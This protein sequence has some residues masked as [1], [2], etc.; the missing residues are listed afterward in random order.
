MKKYK[1]LNIGCKV[2]AY[3]LNAIASLLQ[4][5]GFVEDNENPDVIIVNTCS[6]TV[7]ADRKSRQLIR[8]M[9]KNYPEAVVAVMGCYAQEHHQFIKKEIKPAIVIGTSRRREIVGLI[10]KA[11]VD[12]KPQD[13][14]IDNNPRNFTYEE[15]GIISSSENVRAYLKIQDGC[16]NFCTYC[17]IPYRRGKMR[18]RETANVI[19]E[20]EHLIAQG[21]QEI[22]LTGIHIGGY[23]QDLKNESFSSLVEQLTAL[24]H[25][26]RLRISSIEGSEID[27]HLIRLLNEKPNLAKH[28]HTP[29]QSGS[30]HILKLM[31]RKYSREAFIK[32]IKEIK[33]QVPDVMISSD[34]MVGFPQESEADFLDTYKLCAECFDLLHVFSYSIRPGTVAATMEGQ[35]TAAVKKERSKRLIQLSKNLYANYAKR[36][37]DQTVSVLVERYNIK[38]SYNIGHTSNYLEVKIPNKESKVGQFISVILQKDMI[39]SN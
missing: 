27:D 37:K 25:L 8:R 21:Y 28:L 2:N 17:I 26:K 24:P 1:T 12:R 35:I 11:L 30:N 7:V 19:K 5:E 20:A 36:F 33:A 16:D 15:L 10:K 14:V 23:G 34:V 38:E 6:V 31:N 22:V 39:V 9:Q 29:L 13:S 4:Q 3:E 18:S 32:R